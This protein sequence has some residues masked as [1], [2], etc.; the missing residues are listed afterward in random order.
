MENL[1]TQKGI[2]TNE[3][4]YNRYELLKSRVV[5]VERKFQAFY[6]TFPE[7]FLNAINNLGWEMFCHQREQARVS[8]VKEF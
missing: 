5:L 7:S 4:A 6:L 8:I 3:E 1:P 2:I